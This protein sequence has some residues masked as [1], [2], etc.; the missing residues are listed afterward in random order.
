LVQIIPCVQKQ[1]S[2]PS[3]NGPL[4]S[5]FKFTH[6]Q[7]NRDEFLPHVHAWW[8]SNQQVS[9]AV[10]NNL[11]WLYDHIEASFGVRIFK[12]TDWSID[13]ADW[14]AYGDV[15]ALGMGYYFVETR[16]GYQSQLP[17]NPTKDVIFYFEALTI[18][19][20]VKNVF[21]HSWLPK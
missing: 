5:K 7:T 21:L 15:S 6:N 14:T 8:P 10:V 12:V 1:G 3:Q 13:Q 17:L 4:S 19:A 2:L 9:K 11:H 18:L 20:I 16:C